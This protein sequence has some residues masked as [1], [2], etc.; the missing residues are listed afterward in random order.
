MESEVSK[1]KTSHDSN[2]T[3]LEKYKKLCLEQ[4]KTNKSLESKLDK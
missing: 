2:K 4:L 1:M 3:E